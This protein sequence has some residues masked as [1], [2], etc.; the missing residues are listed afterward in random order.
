MTET[1]QLSHKKNNYDVTA[2]SLSITVASKVQ[3]P[4][5]ITVY[6]VIAD[7]VL[8]IKQLIYSALENV[9]LR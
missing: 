4:S 1:K 9:F 8:S 5:L 3:I 2:A 6:E 7:G